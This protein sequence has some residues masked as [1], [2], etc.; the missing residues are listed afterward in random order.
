MVR[1]SPALACV[2]D[3]GPSPWRDGGCRGVLPAP[4][5][6]TAFALVKIDAERP[7]LLP[8][9]RPV[10]DLEMFRTTQIALMKSPKVLEAA[11][12]DEKVR[13]TSVIAEQADPVGWLENALV[14]EPVTNTEL[15][16]VSLST[17]DA[18][19]G[20][21][22]VNAVTQAYLHEVQAR[23]Q[24]QR[25]ARLKDLT[26]ICEKS[27][28]KK[29]TSLDANDP[30]TAASQQKSAL[31]TLSILQKEMIPIQAELGMLAKMREAG[32]D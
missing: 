22:L 5:R 17:L 14:V 12:Q 9:D 19:E 28:G 27:D 2:F 8:R 26:Q 30:Q 1:S 13:G 3:H 10:V 23:D 25:L 31:D 7:E 20:A 21:I 16:R 24:S 4:A 15:L 32:R 29:D 6:Y 11:L 18:Q